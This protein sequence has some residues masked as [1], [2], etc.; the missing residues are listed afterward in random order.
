M[1]AVARKGDQCLG[2]PPICPPRP[3]LKG[4]SNVFV[5]NRECHRKT[6][7]WAPHCSPPHVGAITTTGSM[8]V[9]VNNLPIARV[10]DLI[11]CG[12]SIGTGSNNVFAG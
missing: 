5:N 8:S 6:D 7:T 1:P 12:T 4:S 10:T 2:H 11:S 9:F 3:N